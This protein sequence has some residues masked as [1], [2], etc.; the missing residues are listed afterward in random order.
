MCLFPVISNESI[1]KRAVDISPYPLPS[2]LGYT[3]PKDQEILFFQVDFQDLDLES[4]EQM[5]LLQIVTR[6]ASLYKKDAAWLISMM[7]NEEKRF[8]SV[9][10]ESR[11][12]M[13]QPCIN[14]SA[15]STVA[16][17]VLRQLKRGETALRSYLAVLGRVLGG[18][19]TPYKVGYFE[20]FSGQTK[21]RRRRFLYFRKVRNIVFA[22][23]FF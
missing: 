16:A 18:V 19:T 6:P 11:S 23:Q 4:L 8:S 7:C 22:T 21:C 9:E 10:L 14:P 12:W 1:V 17:D 3:P 13:L 5:R 2:A 15:F 20:Y